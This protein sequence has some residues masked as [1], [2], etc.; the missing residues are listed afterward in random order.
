MVEHIGIL[1][2]LAIVSFVQNMFFTLSSRSRNSA[3]PGYHRR[4]AW[5]SNGVWFLCQV[6]IVKG[7]WDAI[8]AGNWCFIIAA[9]V[10]YAIFT[11]EGSVLMMKK[12]LKN[13]KGSKR[14]GAQIPKKE[15]YQS[16]QE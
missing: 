6:L 15:G 11:A 3:D 1:V 9:G 14:V 2:L 7:I 12:L 10:V 4:C 8:D 16:C 13:E 5:G